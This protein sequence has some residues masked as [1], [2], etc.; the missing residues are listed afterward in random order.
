M[1]QKTQDETNDFWV[2]YT[3]LV[4]GFMI[5]FIVTTLLLANKV[6][7]GNSSSDEAAALRERNTELIN[8]IDSLKSDLNKRGV[9]A[10]YEE[11]VTE[12]EKMYRDDEDIKVTNDAT[13]RFS[14]KDNNE[15]FESGKVELTSYFKNKLYYFIDGYYEQIQ[16]INTDSFQVKEIRIEGHTNS[17][18]DYYENLKLSSGRAIKVQQAVLSNK[19]FQN[20]PENFQ[21]FVRDNTI[22][23]GYSFSKRLNTNGEIITSDNETED[24][25]QSKRVEFRVLLEPKKVIK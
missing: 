4:T 25:N 16:L 11:L 6:E 19:H 1:F 22:A 15:L 20:Y 23:V 8:R 3:D 14:V 17:E 5:I 7:K 2:S 21:Q 13:I 18:G 10:K 12:F 9:A 24:M